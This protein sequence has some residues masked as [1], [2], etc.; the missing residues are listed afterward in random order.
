MLKRIFQ[1]VLRIRTYISVAS[2]KRKMHE[3]EKEWIKRHFG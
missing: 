3:K 1:E 2:Y